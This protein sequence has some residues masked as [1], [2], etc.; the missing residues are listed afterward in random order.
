MNL[1]VKKIILAL[2]AITTATAAFSQV[3]LS[4]GPTTALASTLQSNTTFIDSVYRESN[5][6][7]KSSFT[8]AGLD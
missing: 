1:I 5:G 7:F 8:A 6:T 4:T 3:S 2:F